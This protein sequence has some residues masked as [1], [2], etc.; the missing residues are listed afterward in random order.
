MISDDLLG[1]PD[2]EMSTDL[3]MAMKNGRT[4]IPTHH[5]GS[6]V[7]SRISGTPDYSYVIGFFANALKTLHI[8]WSLDVAEQL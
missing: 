5:L 6:V 3:L 2:G 7:I 4:L 1:F 8:D